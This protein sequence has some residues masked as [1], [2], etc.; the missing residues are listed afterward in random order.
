MCC[1]ILTVSLN[2][3]NAFWFY[4]M[5]TKSIEAFAPAAKVADKGKKAE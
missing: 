2:T 5:C 3:L 1:R 4:K